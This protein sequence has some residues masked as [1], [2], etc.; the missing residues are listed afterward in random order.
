MTV[1]P[2]DVDELRDAVA[3]QRQ[4]EAK[5]AALDWNLSAKIEALDWN[6]GRKRD[7]SSTNREMN[8]N[9]RVRK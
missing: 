6:L 8:N 5:I 3:D 7:S 4:V 9:S 2:L 1:G